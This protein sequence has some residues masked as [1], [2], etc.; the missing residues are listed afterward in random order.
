[1]FQVGSVALSAP[2][3]F[4]PGE[5]HHPGAG[6][7]RWT[8]TPT[9]SRQV[10][11]FEALMLRSGRALASGTTRAREEVDDQDCRPDQELHSSWKPGQWH[12]MLR[13]CSAPASG[14][15]RV[16]E[17]TGEQERRH[18]A[19]RSSLKPGLRSDPV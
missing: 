10:S 7:N 13:S 14:A 6:A 11:V 3:L 12:F 17:D 15:A 4:D 9:G 19:W 16:Q 8:G 1:M 18:Q 2:I 5:W